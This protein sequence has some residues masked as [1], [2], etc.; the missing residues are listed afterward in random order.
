[1]KKDHRKRNK[2]LIEENEIKKNNRKREKKKEKSLKERK[3]FIEKGNKEIMTE[4]GK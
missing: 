1:M 4:K 3:I 2:G